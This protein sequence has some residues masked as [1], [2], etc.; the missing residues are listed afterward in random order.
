MHLHGAY[1]LSMLWFLGSGGDED[2]AD[3]MPPPSRQRKRVNQV[4]SQTTS[5]SV[6]KTIMQGRADIRVSTEM[7][8]TV[9]QKDKG[10]PSGFLKGNGSRHELIDFVT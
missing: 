2:E 10:R 1:V 3:L 8:N 7:S 6:S 5:G 4:V 9:P